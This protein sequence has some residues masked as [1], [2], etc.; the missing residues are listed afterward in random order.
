MDALLRL[1]RI[2]RQVDEIRSIDD[3]KKLSDAAAAAKYF[4]KKSN[5]GGDLI[6]F[7]H[8]VQVRAD[9]AGGR[10]LLA[11][12]LKPGPRSIKSNGDSIAIRELG[13]SADRLQSWRVLGALSET[14]FAP[15]DRMEKTVTQVR[16]E[17]REARRQAK[18]D[19]NAQAVQAADLRC[20][21]WTTFRHRF[22]C[23]A[24]DPPWDWGDEG[25]QDQLGRARPEYVTMPIDE[26]AALPVGD[27]ADPNGAHMYLWITNRSLP[28]GFGLLEAWGFRY[29]TTLTWCKPSFGMGNYFR[30]QTE[31]VLFGVKGSLPI[32]RKDVGTW[33]A[34]PR[35]PIEHSAKPEQF[36][37][38]AESCSPG[39][40]ADV[41]SRSA[42]PGWTSIGAEA[43]TP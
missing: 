8:S 23:I 34:A 25:D 1:D 10:L 42:R 4:A 21:D 15:V 24:I 40:R 5:K 33:F 19:Q 29:V 30:G 6:R 32:N 13:L 26:I 18:R 12:D 38:L 27:C 2:N 35:G 43:P 14:D 9:R 3:A 39:P 37:F 17:A 31:H 22:A 20:L 28:K 41:F 36:Y 11:A 16:R 7:A